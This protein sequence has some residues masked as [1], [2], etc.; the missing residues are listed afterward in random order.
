VVAE[1]GF[2]AHLRTIKNNGLRHARRPNMKDDIGTIRY[3]A[4]IRSCFQ[5]AACG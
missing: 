5:R 4:K 1:S 2:D 3:D